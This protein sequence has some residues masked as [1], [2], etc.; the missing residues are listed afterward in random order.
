LREAAPNDV[1]FADSNPD[2]GATLVS[3]FGALRLRTSSKAGPDDR[4]AATGSWS[5]LT[6]R[7]APFA[8]LMTTFLGAT[9]L[10]VDHVTV[11]GTDLKQMQVRLA[12][13]GIATEYGGPH[14]NGGTQ[15][16]LASFPDGSYLE[17][18]APQTNPDQK[19]LTAHYW[20]KQI[21]GDAGPTAWAVR[22]MDVA[23]EV[24]RLR[25]AGITVSSPSRSG[26]KRPDGFALEWETAQ[27]GEEPNGTFF[28]FLIRDFTPRDAR[29]FPKGQPTAKDLKGVKL[30]VIAVRDLKASMARY[31]QAFGLPPAAEQEDPSFG[32][33]L[34]WFAGTPVVLA[35]PNHRS[36]RP[37]SWLAKRIER[38]GEGPCAFVLGAQAGVHSGAS[39]TGW[40]GTAIWWVN[41][42]SLGW[43][44]GF[45]E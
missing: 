5:G 1:S 43:H 13:V 2:G 33:R 22:A 21:Q 4:L 19:A 24:G 45:E 10:T 12:A 40:F 36:S 16:A 30:V 38:F 18:I 25:A 34:A 6:A 39:K 3:Y 42:E 31:R 41:A 7:V 23:A 37:P 29:A 9:D 17:L 15:M 20:S 26:R 44:L 35:T 8:L 14:S 11:A 32:A 27:I 28:P